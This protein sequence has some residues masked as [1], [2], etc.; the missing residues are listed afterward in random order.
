MQLTTDVVVIGGGVIGCAIAYY[1]SKQGIDVTV[2]ERGEIGG[3][4]SGAAAGIFS[5]LKP[6]AK[7]D[8]YNRLLLASRALFPLLMVELEAV[9]G[10]NPEFEQISTLRTVHTPN[11]KVEPRLY[12]WAE[13]CNGMG[14][15]VELLSQEAAHKLEPLL[16][17]DICAATYIANEGQVR[18]PLLVAAYAQGAMRY[19]ATIQTN[20]EVVNV[21]HSSRKVQGVTTN[22]GEYIVCNTLIV[23]S[24]AWVAQ[25]REWLDV[26]LPVIPQRGQCV[27]LQQPASPLQNIVLGYGVYLAPKQDGTLIIGATQEEVGFDTHVTASGL[28]F[29]LDAAIKLVPSLAESPVERIWAGLRPKTPDNYPI[30]GKLANW[31]NVLVAT[32]HSSFGMLLSA[33]TGQTI[34]ELVLHGQTPEILRPFSLE[35][36]T[37][38]DDLLS[39]TINEQVDESK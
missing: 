5:L 23:A 33:I 3:E 28:Y 1:L 8:A 19:G 12:N 30:L 7:I 36:F 2:L 11:P 4:A 9:S 32:G 16:S 13:S 18:A 27:S 24:G 37:K 38:N 25:C 6:L 21:T 15:H 31:E 26:A 29:L 35:R 34:A 14:L 20:T 22:T 10:I 39:A 17:P